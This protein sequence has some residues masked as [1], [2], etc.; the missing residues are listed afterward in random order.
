M[1]GK[2][3]NHKEEEIKDPAVD[4][5]PAGEDVL[6]SDAVHE[7]G[8][9]VEQLQLLQKECAELKDR[10][11]RLVADFENARKRWDRDRD[12]LFK[13]A[14]FAIFK[15]L[16]SVVDTMESALKA[17]Q[18]HA[19]HD[20]VVKGLEMTHSNLVNVL[21][22]NGLEAI[23]AKGKKF[24]PNFHEVVLSKPCEGEEHIVLEEAQKGYVYNGKLLRA[25]KVI[26][27]VKAN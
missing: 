9:S 8:P 15:E 12:D 21:K 18:V 24:D 26:I 7:Q 4:K 11:L 2:N 16:L 14:N 25:S 20:E 10:N 27:S 3:H 1:N 22:K 17:A 19:N 6:A 13:F 5:E 23:E